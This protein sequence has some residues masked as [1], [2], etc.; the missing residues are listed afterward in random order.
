MVEPGQYAHEAEIDNTLEAEQAAVGGLID[1]AYP[2]KE[3]TCIVCN[4]EGLINGMQ[5]NRMVEKYG[6]IAG[7]FFICGIDG[8][9]FCSLTPEQIQKYKAMFLRPQIFLPTRRGIG[10]CEYDNVHLPDAPEEAK[11]RFK[12]HKG[13]PDICFC[14]H[15]SDGK[16][17]LIK[18]GTDGYYL[19]EKGKS[20]ASERACVDEMNQRI[21]VNKQQEA[22][23]LW[24][25]MFGWERP[26]ADP[27]RYDQDG[28]PLS[29][30]R[31]KWDKDRE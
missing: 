13:C 3:L 25:A 18:Y 9:N 5:L 24:G 21:G 28:V 29:S 20:G 14:L 23:M 27:A 16:M 12:A 19:C 22:A 11:A 30:R 31:Q 2:W 17:I 4:D 10:Y 8:E 7:P 15:P 1:C 26:S 6:P